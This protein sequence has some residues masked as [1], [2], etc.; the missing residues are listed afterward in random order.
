LVAALLLHTTADPDLWGHLAFGRQ[1]VTEGL[2]RTDAFSYTAPGVPVLNHEWLSDVV[3]YSVFRRVGPVGLVGLRL[4]LLAGMLLVIA[5]AVRRACG[6]GLAAALLAAL[7]V[8]GGF[9]WFVT[10]RPQLWT[11]L[12]F[13]FFLLAMVCAD[14]GNTR[15]LR[16]TPLLTLAWVNLHGG[17]VAGLG[18]LGCWAGLRAGQA[19]LRGVG[20][21]LPATLARGTP[22]ARVVRTIVTVCALHVPAALVNPFGLELWRFF[23]ET[24]SVPR[25]EIGEW[26]PLSFTN[27]GDVLG[28]AALAAMGL[29]LVRSRRPHDLVHLFLMLAL[30]VGATG[31]RRHLALALLGVAIL[32]APHVASALTGAMPAAAGRRRFGVV[33]AAA[34][35]TTLLLWGV[36]LTRAGCI[37]VEPGTVPQAAVGYLKAS[38]AEGRLAVLFDWGSYAIWHLAPRLRVS[39]D[40]RREAVY[41][42]AQLEENAAFLYG[43]A[44]WRAALDRD[45]VDLALVSR[46]FAVHDRLGAEP[47]WRLAFAA[48]ES[49]LFVRRG[50]PADALLART[51]PPS[52]APAPL[53]LSRAG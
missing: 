1:T 34:L 21:R 52:A 12:F 35:A 46:R 37:V 15:P 40:G 45:A 26:Q 29:L 43:Q 8:V 20:V 6:D 3:I 18:V 14:G 2:G 5:R 23:A 9:P 10:A 7:V 51:P 42:P 16:L 39:I 4:L 13:G 50:S 38:G 11:F 25:M 27:L 30:T 19:A 49:A 36:G 32:G 41:S 33:P 44:G 48:D 17:I 22:D 53:C 24:L 31:A 47:D 28:V